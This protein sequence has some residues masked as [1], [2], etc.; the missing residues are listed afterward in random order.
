MKRAHRK[1]FAA[2]LRTA[3][4]A[5]DEARKLVTDNRSTYARLGHLAVELRFIADSFAGGVHGKA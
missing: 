3:A 1:A 2:L 5:I 4:D